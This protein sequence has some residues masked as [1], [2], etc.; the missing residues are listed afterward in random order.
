MFFP[1][2]EFACKYVFLDEIAV[3]W[4][5]FDSASNTTV[6]DFQLHTVTVN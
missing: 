2:S 1:T 3:I 6:S 4:F 5:F